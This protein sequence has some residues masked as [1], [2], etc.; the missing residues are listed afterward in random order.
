LA[1]AFISASLLNGLIGC[2]AEPPQMGVGTAADASGNHPPVVHSLS[3]VPDPIVRRGVVTAV[4]ETKDADQDEVQLRFRWLV[5]DAPVGGAS[6]PTFDPT[7]MKRGDRLAVEVTPYD[8]KVEGKPTRAAD[9]VVGNTPPAVRAVVLEPNGA[10]AG[11]P[12]K[13]IVDGNDVD[14]DAVRYIYRWLRNNQVALEGEQDS[15]D[16]AGFLRDDVVA[17]AIIPHDREAQGKEVLSQPITL[18]NRPPKFTSTA[19]ASMAQGQFSYAV[20]AVDPENDP[21]T[22]LLESA[23]P[24][25][26]IDERTGHIQWAVPAVATGS[27]MVKVVVKDSREGWASQEFAV[28]LKSSSSS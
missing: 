2:T 25:M 19:P 17:V 23:P 11:D 20:T 8:G 5:N 3:L 13:A 9:K 7:S 4:V 12:I 24:G 6:S 16:T 22:F 27:Y 15:L 10:K 18:A 26:T 21:V 14:G 1:T 28:G